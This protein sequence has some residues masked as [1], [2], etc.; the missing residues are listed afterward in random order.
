MAFITL[1][2]F[3][4][5]GKTQRAS[6][7]VAHL[8]QHL[9]DPSYTGPQFQISV[10]SDDVLNIDRSAYDGLFAA[11]NATLAQPDSKAKIVALKNLREAPY[12]RRCNAKWARTLS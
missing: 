1:S 2:G 11:L 6:Q 7:L 8:R 10:L 12:S 4:S 5:S 9:E 3:P